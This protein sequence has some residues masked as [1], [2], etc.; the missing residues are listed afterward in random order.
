MAHQNMRI[1]QPDATY[2]SLSALLASPASSASSHLSLIGSNSLSASITHYLATL[3]TEEASKFAR[4]LVTSRAFWND[5]ET[6]DDIDTNQTNFADDTLSKTQL[7]FE[8]TA[9]SV[10]GRIQVI[11]HQYKGNLGWSAQRALVSWIR[12]LSDAIH[13]DLESIPKKC[14]P[15]PIS[16]FALQTGL[17]AGLQAARAQ[18]KQ[19]DSTTGGPI[20]STGT[21]SSNALSTRYALRRAEEE[22]CTT[23]AESLRR[24]TENEASKAKEDSEEDEWEREFRRVSLHAGIEQARKADP[25]NDPQTILLFLAAQVSPYVSARRLSLL[26]PGD[27]I[28][29]LSDT[30]LDLFEGCG[31]FQSLREDIYQDAQGLLGLSASSGTALRAQLLNDHPLFKVFGP[32]SRLLSLAFSNITRSLNPAQV[33]EVLLGLS[34]E[35]FSAPLSRMY[36]IAFA[37]ETRWLGSR[38]AGA[39]EREIL[40]SSR[41]QTKLLWGVFKTLLFSYTMIF[42]AL[43]EAIVDVCPTPT[44]TRPISVNASENTEVGN[45]WLATTESN[46]PPVYLQIVRTIL[47]TYSKLSWVISTFGTG[48]FDA[49]RRV[50]YEALEVLSRDGRASVALTIRLIPSPLDILQTNAAR[51]AKA[52]FFLDVVE[53]L[54]IQLPDDMIEDVILPACR[55]YLDDRTYQEAF[56]SAHSV[57]LSIYSSGKECLLELTPYYSQLLLTC[58]PT[59]LSAEQLTL[60]F[61][62]VVDAVSDRSDTL[63][64]H[65]LELLWSS[66]EHERFM[67][68]HHQKKLTVDQPKPQQDDT[69]NATVNSSIESV[70]KPKDPEEEDQSSKREKELTDVYVA[71]IANVNLVLLRSVLDRVKRLI[72]YRTRASEERL[73]LCQRTF[74]SLAGLDASTREEGVR[75]WLAERERFGV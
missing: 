21:L 48:G 50:F 49:Y 10:L 51:R 63:A 65:T 37:W 67:Y 45:K 18:R 15:L 16:S 32:L 73:H 1:E 42:D 6:A 30:M 47:L 34:P 8:A 70:V 58:F 3:P 20:S 14:Q 19:H 54:M 69:T 38:L 22:W 31:I 7:L 40:R 13:V 12:A 41:P 4:Q 61:S 52:T 17:V 28:K 36:A 44:E 64:W 74:A 39:E 25:R 2:K 62:T 75:W 27:V 55:P 33:Q 60:A 5:A 23:L 9:R 26:N 68:A 56:E 66:I 29:V 46:I 43:M 57:V 53:Q 71:Q 59:N 72:M 24:M 35:T 11:V